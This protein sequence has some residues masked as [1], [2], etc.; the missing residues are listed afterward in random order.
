MISKI[1]SAK[2]PTVFGVFKIIIFK[3][4]KDDSEHAVLIGEKKLKTPTLIRIHSQC[5]TGD[6]FSSLK[7][8]C[9]EQLVM[10]MGKIGGE[11]GVLIYLNQEGRGI[12]LSNKIKAYALQDEGLD[13]IEANKKLGLAVD[14]RDYEIAA[15]I[16]KELKISKIILMTNNPDKAN[17]L[18]KYGVNVIKCIS[19]EVTPN[20]INK[21]YLKT[22]KEKLGHK[23][24]LV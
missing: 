4:T 9:K 21:Y 16:L 8:D 10:S 18:K 12:G 6:T 3:S 22:K 23:L 1:S 2:L 20:Q 11:G 19:A 7:C 5:L 14:N 24:R 13:T 17:Q 15:K